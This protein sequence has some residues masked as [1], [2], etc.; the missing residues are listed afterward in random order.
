MYRRAELSVLHCISLRPSCIGELRLVLVLT[1]LL[2][3]VQKYRLYLKRLSGVSPGLGRNKSGKF[4]PDAQFQAL[5]AGNQVFPPAVQYV[6][7]VPTAA[8]TP[9]MI[10]VPEMANMAA[11]QVLGSAGSG[12]QSMGSG[13][14]VPA[15]QLTGMVISGRFSREVASFGLEWERPW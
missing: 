2:L 7:P 15:A 8:V 9:G 3:C 1:T 4:Q 5:M 6:P 12:L 10:A 13:Q 14:A 11:M